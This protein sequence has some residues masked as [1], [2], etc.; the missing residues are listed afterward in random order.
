MVQVRHQQIRSIAA[1]SAAT[2]AAVAAVSDQR[3]RR[4]PVKPL[5]KVPDD[6]AKLLRKI[7]TTV[8][9]NIRLRGSVTKLTA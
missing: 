8:G 2:A 3:S 5:T 1:T 4:D 7:S 9:S 6:V